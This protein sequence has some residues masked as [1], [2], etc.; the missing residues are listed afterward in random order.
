MRPGDDARASKSGAVGAFLQNR[1]GFKGSSKPNSNGPG[2]LRDEVRIK[3]QM[4][5]N[6]ALIDDF[7]QG[8]LMLTKPTVLFSDRLTID[9]GNLTLNLDLLR[10]P[11]TRVGHTGPCP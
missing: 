4:A 7:R 5:E 11:P 6:A 8:R 2:R 9:L 1:A 10:A 3:E